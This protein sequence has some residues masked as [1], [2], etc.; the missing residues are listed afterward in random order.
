MNYPVN[1]L[2][3]SRSKKILGRGHDRL[4]IFGKGK[5]VHSTEYFKQLMRIVVDKG[6]LQVSNT[7]KYA[8]YQVSPLG[9]RYLQSPGSL[10]WDLPEAL[11]KLDRTYVA[12]VLPFN[13]SGWCY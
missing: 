4:M 3:G 5:G 7:D 11:I 12:F 9:H 6:Y 8:L 10:L 1:V 13:Q 2:M